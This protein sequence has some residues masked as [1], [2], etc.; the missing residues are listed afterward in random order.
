MQFISALIEHLVVGIIALV[1]LLP[2]AHEHGLIKD[3]LIAQYKDVLVYIGPPVAYVVGMYIDTF[4]SM[5][6]AYLRARYKT[7]SSRTIRIVECLAPS[8]G[9]SYTRTARILAQSPDETGK[10][11]LQLSGRVKIARGVALTLFVAAI[12]YA[13]PPYAKGAVPAIALLALS[14]L[15]SLVWLRLHVQTDSFKAHAQAKIGKDA[16]EAGPAPSQ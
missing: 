14:A 8:K 16:S 6:S 11:L 15:G 9:D 4:A 3:G 7:M 10:Y 1:C 13:F 12:A 5:L 2:L